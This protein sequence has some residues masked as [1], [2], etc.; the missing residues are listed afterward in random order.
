MAN[1]RQQLLGFSRRVSIATTQTSVSNSI[2]IVYESLDEIIDTK[3]LPYELIAQAS[4]VSD[5]YIELLAPVAVSVLKDHENQQQTSLSII[6]HYESIQSVDTSVLKDYENEQSILQ[7]D[8]SYLEHLL[9]GI[10]A[11]IVKNCESSKQVIQ[12]RLKQYEQTQTIQNAIL[13]AMEWLGEQAVSN[14]V[15]IYYE[16]EK[17]ILQSTGTFVEWL[18]QFSQL[19]SAEFENLSIASSSVLE[20]YENQQRIAKETLE[21]YESEQS[22]F[23]LG[24]SYLEYLLGGI[25]LSNAINYENL[26]SILDSTTE[27]MEWQGATGAVSNSVVAYIEYIGS[28]SSNVESDFEHLSFITKSISKDIEWNQVVLNTKDSFVEFMQIASTSVISFVEWLGQQAVSNTIDIYFE[29]IGVISNS[30]IG[31]FEWATTITRLT[32]GDLE[33]LAD[34]IQTVKADIEHVASVS[35]SIEEYFANIQQITKSVAGYMEWDGTS[36]LAFITA[37]IA[38]YAAVSGDIDVNPAVI[39]DSMDIDPPVVGDIDIDSIG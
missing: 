26:E 3:L 36:Q 18:L 12:L 10:V 8:D 6:K 17:S 31:Y 38:I 20:D 14:A 9:S 21:A 5:L 35:N 27:Y 39:A 13:T 11:S 23:V 2:G 15:L 30:T 24:I 19:D 16:N 22:I 37:T 1:D 28:L 25:S 32:Q 29:S 7:V 34:A 4:D 33:N